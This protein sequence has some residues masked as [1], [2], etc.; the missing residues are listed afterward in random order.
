MG[1]VNFIPRDD[2]RPVR[3]DEL[4]ILFAMVKKIKVSP[5]QPMIKQWLEN[6]R[7]TETIEC[8]T[9]ITWI[10]S[11]IGVLNF[12]V[13]IPLSKNPKF[14]LMKITLFKVIP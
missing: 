14:A 2:V 10:A 6:F 8:T 3:Q 11:N 7:I 5:I 13:Q 12:G 4:Y 9:L 1:S